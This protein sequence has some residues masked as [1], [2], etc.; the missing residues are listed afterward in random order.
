MGVNSILYSE[1]IES[2]EFEILFE[3]FWS[4]I[5]FREIYM[6]GKTKNF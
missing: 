3:T 1:K 6:Y 5:E 2:N 4:A